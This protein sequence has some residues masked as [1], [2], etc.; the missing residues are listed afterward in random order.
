MIFS[1]VWGLVFGKNMCQPFLNNFGKKISSKCDPPLLRK[2]LQPFHAGDD[3]H[4]L[5]TDSWCTCFFMRLR[6]PRNWSARMGS[7]HTNGPI[8][9][10]SFF[11]LLF[12]N[13]FQVFFSLHPQQKK[14]AQHPPSHFF[15][16]PHHPSAL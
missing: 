13:L 14:G 16:L 15:L 7:K 9:F 10:P 4:A 2:I 8:F 1:V 11:P 5:G 6:K 3:D 12:K